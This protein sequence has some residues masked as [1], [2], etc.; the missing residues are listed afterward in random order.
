MDMLYKAQL[1][2]QYADNTISLKECEK[3]L[4]DQIAASWKH[5]TCQ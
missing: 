4:K 3:T 1:Y 2:Y 5:N